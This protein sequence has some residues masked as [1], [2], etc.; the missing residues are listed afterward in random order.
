M[1]EIKSVKNFAK[2]AQFEQKPIEVNHVWLDDGTE[3]LTLDQGVN[4]H[5]ESV[6]VSLQTLGALVLALSEAERHY[7]RNA[8]TD[9]NPQ[10]LSLF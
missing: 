6:V 9:T 10:Q 1:P 5:V 2:V 7:G 4:G 8:Y 3:V